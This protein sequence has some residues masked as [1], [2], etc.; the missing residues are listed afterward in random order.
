MSAL[1][2]RLGIHTGN[3]IFTISNGRYVLICKRCGKETT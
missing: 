1:L 3:R 2:C